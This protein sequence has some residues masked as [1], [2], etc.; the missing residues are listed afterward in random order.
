MHWC[1]RHRIDRSKEDVSEDSECSYRK[2][3]I[4]NSELTG[5]AKK[6]RS[7]HAWECIRGHASKRAQGPE[8]VIDVK[9]V[10]EARQS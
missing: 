10:G 7:S 4:S 9:W 3:P 5:P 2:H 8:P 6:Y 1:G